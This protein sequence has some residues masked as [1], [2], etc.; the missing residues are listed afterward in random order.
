MCGWCVLGSGKCVEGNATSPLT[1]SCPHAWYFTSCP[2]DYGTFIFYSDFSGLSNC[3]NKV[4]L[5]SCRFLTPS[6]CCSVSPCWE[7]AKTITF[8]D[9]TPKNGQPTKLSFQINGH[10]YCPSNLPLSILVYLNNR[11]L[12]VLSGEPD[13]SL[14]SCMC[15]DPCDTPLSFTYDFPPDM[16]G[17]PYHY[18]GNNTLTLDVTKGST[19]IGQLYSE[20]SYGPAWHSS[21]G[22]TP[23]RL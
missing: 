10:L 21:L 9:Q 15:R 22:D 19:C 14:S 5:N 13:P 18:G 3:D 23:P 2:I 8:Q 7:S 11:Y 12:G 20:V 6:Y 1:G 17:F 16:N 4:S